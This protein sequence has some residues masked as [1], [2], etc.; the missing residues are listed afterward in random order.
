MEIAASL[1]SS[2]FLLYLVNKGARCDDNSEILLLFCR[3]DIIGHVKDFRDNGI[4]ALLDAG[5]N[6]N[7]NDFQITPLQ[8]AMEF[9]YLY[10]DHIR[11]LLKADADPNA[12]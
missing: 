2:D 10:T 8:A 7:H 6:P 12:V 4:K 11:F 1:R 3:C 5:A 9:G